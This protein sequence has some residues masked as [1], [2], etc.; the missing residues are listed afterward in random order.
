[1]DRIYL[2]GAIGG[3][4]AYADIA[5]AG[6][7]VNGAG[8]AGPL[9][10]VFAG[11]NYQFAPRWL[12]GAEAEIAPSVRSTDLKLGWIGAVRARFGYLLMPDTLLYAT[13]GWIGTEIDDLVDRGSVIVAGQRING[14]QVGGG[15]E[16][17]FAGHW[18][19]RFDY[20][21]AIME[22]VDLAFPLAPGL[23]VA[24]SEPR[25]HTGRIAIVRRFGG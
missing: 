3:T 23:T 18:S 4:V 6:A 16:A 17:A 2:G 14:V 11:V 13:A 1:M 12:V 24:V 7:G 22:K 19:T 8:L 21:Y 15:I 5:V 25:G 10:S 20:Q 9:P